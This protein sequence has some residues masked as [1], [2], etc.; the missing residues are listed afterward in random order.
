MKSSRL[1][2]WVPAV[3]AC[4]FLLNACTPNTDVFEKNVPIP[5]HS[6][7]KR[8][9]PTIDFTVKDTSIQYRIFVVIRHSDAYRYRNIWLNVQSVAPNGDTSKQ[10]LDLR[11]ATDDKGWLGSGMDDLF[12]HRI[13]ITRPG[14]LQ[15]GTY[16]FSLEQIMREDPLEYVMNAGIRV[17]KVQQ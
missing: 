11:L 5:E 12:D 8:F 13:L 2:S 10:A 6:W 4:L 16:H 7:S 15:A 1:S 9:K 17:E 14:L 3:L